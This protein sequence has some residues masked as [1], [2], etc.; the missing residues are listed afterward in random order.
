MCLLKVNTVRYN[1]FRKLL[2]FVL[3]TSILL[4][5]CYWFRSGHVLH[6]NSKMLYLVYYSRISPIIKVGEIMI[7]ML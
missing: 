2:Y 1:I 5:V 6:N 3:I 4:L 7:T